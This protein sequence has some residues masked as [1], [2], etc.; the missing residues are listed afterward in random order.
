MRLVDT[1]VWVDHLRHGLP[2]LA[3]ALE[4]GEVW[5]HPW[6][7]GELACGNLQNRAQ[8]LNLLQSLPSAKVA[9]DAEVLRLIEQ[10]RLMGHGIGYLDAHLLASARLTHCQL[11]TQDRRLVALAQQLGQA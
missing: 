11:W 10:H 3:A 9:T 5:I 7:V 1:S 4:N 6:V 2:E 8:I